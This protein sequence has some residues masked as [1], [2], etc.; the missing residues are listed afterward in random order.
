MEHLNKAREHLFI[1]MQQTLL[2]TLHFQQPVKQLLAQVQRLHQTFAVGNFVAI[3]NGTVHSVREVTAITNNTILTVRGFP[4]FASSQA[5]IQLTPTGEIFYYEST[6]QL[7]EMH[8]IKSTAANATFKFANTNSIVGSESGANATITEVENINMTAFDNM[9][10]QIT[11]ADTALTQFHQSNTATGQTANT[12]FPINNRNR[13]TEVAIIKSR[14]NEI[15]DGTG[16]SLKH[17]FLFNSA[18]SHLSPVL[19]DGISNILRV[20]NIN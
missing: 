7:R 10:Y 11:P 3:T 4:D 20:E 5:D 12:Q 13:L 1:T 15:V 8:L 17:T 19:D 6:N 14:S 2:V 9:I 16:K 18:K